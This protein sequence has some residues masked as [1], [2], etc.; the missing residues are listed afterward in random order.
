M[1]GTR[2]GLVVIDSCESAGL[3]ADSNNA[4]PW[5]EKHVDPWL[6]AGATVLL[7]DHVPKRKEDRPIG[8]IGSQHKLARVKGAAIFVSG[9]AWTKAEGG[10][11][12]LINHKDANGD[13]PAPLLK[14]VALVTVTPT[15]DGLLAYSITKPGQDEDVDVTDDLLYQ[16]A[17]LGTDGVT[18]SKNVRALVK[19]KPESTEGHRWTA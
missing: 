16:I 10:T 4:K 5:Y 6:D 1:G 7:L 12:T 18:G 8:A 9:R 13:L 19:A 17:K 14:K 11:V 15:E 3:P 2:P